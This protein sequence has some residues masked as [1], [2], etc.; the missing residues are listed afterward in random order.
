MDLR[1]VDLNLLVALDALLAERNVT[2]AAARLSIGQSAM[3]A[4]LGRLR[5]LLDDEL[6]VRDG[7]ELVLTPLAGALEAPLREVLADVDAVL[8]L[9]LD[10]D[11]ATAR[12]RFTILAGD[13][14]TLTFLKPVL[15]RLRSEAPHV[16][17][18]VRPPGEDYAD[19]L[20][21]R[22]ADV[23]VLPRSA[24]PEEHGL[25]EVILF[26]DRWVLA[27]DAG[28]PEVGE[29]VT[30]EQFNALPHLAWGPG[31]L[32]ALGAELARV[33]GLDDTAH[34]TTSE[35]AAV[36][37]IHGTRLVTV[38]PSRLAQ[39][40]GRLVDIRTIEPPMPLPLVSET[41][42]W[43]PGADHDPGHRWLRTQ[44]TRGSEA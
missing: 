41:L 44:L 5:R 21:S 42:F 18:T 20:R 4:S 12:R 16:R 26:Q 37:M 14:V 22:R 40:A 13:F 2:R 30:M 7:R 43:A 17:I 9:G 28:H 32:P 10:F 25:R 38:V 35:G 29:K 3:S 15:V 11:P 24:L 19:L 6:L 23:V 33:A 27:L 34:L 36:L 31:A 1:R 8:S 39:W